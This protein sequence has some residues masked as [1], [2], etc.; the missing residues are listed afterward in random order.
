MYLYRPRTQSLTKVILTIAHL[1]HDIHNN[2][3]M[4]PGGAR[5]GKSALPLEDS[6]LAALCQK[7]HNQYDGHKRA[8][9]RIK[10]RRKRL[11]KAGQLQIA[12]ES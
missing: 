10:N 4:E 1:D 8:Q 9:S 11:E 5:E 7:C 12:A 2:D 6:N 3:G